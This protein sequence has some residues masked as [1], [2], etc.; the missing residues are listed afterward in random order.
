MAHADS[1]YLP[2]VRL[3]EIGSVFFVRDGNHRVSVAKTMGAYQIDAEVSSLDT[4]I[5]LRPGM[6][7]EEVKKEVVQFEQDQLFKNTDLG[8]VIEPEKLVFAA[9]GR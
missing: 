5:E 2:A 7:P 3:Y 4:D 9:T 1:V 6:S 8:K